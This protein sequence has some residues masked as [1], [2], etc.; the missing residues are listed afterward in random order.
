MNFACLIGAN[1]RVPLLHGN[2]QHRVDIDLEGGKTVWV[3]LHRLRAV[4][5]LT[6]AQEV[7]CIGAVRVEANLITEVAAQQLG[8]RLP[9]QLAGQIPER[10]IDPAPD[11]HCAS[12]L[13][14]GVEHVVKVY[15]NRQRVLA[16]QPQVGQPWSLQ[17]RNRLT[18][19]GATAM[20]L[21][22]AGN[23]RIGLDLDEGA[24]VL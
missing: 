7:T 10:N 14:I 12:P 22:I 19:K 15:V 23:L 3:R 18:S 2:A 8:N 16:D 9:Q 13:W 21:T 1:A 20:T 11:A 4:V 5:P 24:S 6:F 17:R